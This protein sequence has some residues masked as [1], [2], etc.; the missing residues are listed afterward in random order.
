M[1]LCKKSVC[2]GEAI[3]NFKTLECN[4]SNNPER[5]LHIRLNEGKIPDLATAEGANLGIMIYNLW[6]SSHFY[7]WIQLPKLMHQVAKLPLGN[8]LSV[9]N[10]EIQ[11]VK[12]RI[13]ISRFQNLR[14]FDSFEQEKANFMV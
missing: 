10:I 8:T 5:R 14:I 12:P 2:T 1:W 4:Y 11:S 6:S 3:L 7:S 13:S 9:D